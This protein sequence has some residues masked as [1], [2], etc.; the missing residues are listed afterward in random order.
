MAGGLRAAERRAL[1]AE[2]PGAAAL[3][4]ARERA[5]R[6]A[7]QVVAHAGREL[8]RVAVADPGDRDGLCAGL[9]ATLGELLLEHCLRGALHAR[10]R[11]LAGHLVRAVAPKQLQEL[12]VGAVDEGRRAL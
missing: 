10:R 12:P 7:A 4:G 2:G 3:E 6:R 8:R 9:R 1:G 5:P 11:D